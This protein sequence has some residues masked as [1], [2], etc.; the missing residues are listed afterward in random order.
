[1]QDKW[2]G[3]HLHYSLHRQLYLEVPVLNNSKPHFFIVKEVEFSSERFRMRRNKRQV[4][5]VMHSVSQLNL[6]LGFTK[7]M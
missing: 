5:T 4:F 1:M 7:D 6:S 2:L 3:T